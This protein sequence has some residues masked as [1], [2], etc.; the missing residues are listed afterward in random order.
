MDRTS[1]RHFI[2][3]KWV[4]PS[5][6]AYFQSYNP[7]TEEP[8]ADV[9]LGTAR[10]VQLAV[11][12]ARR[13]FD[14]GP[15]PRMAPAARRKILQDVAQIVSD[16]AN[17]L[18]HLETI[19][20]GKPIASTKNR[21][22]PFVC[23]MLRYYA[24]WADKIFGTLLPEN[25]G[26]MGYTIR[27]PVG[28]VGIVTPWNSPLILSVMKIA[29]ALATGNVLIHKPA[30]WTPLSAIRFAE[31]AVEAGL[32]VGVLNVVMGSGS[33]VGRSLVTHSGVDKIS[34]TGETET[35]KEIMRDASTTLKRVSLELGGKSP[36]IIFADAPNL[37][38]AASFAA[39][40]FCANQGQICWAGSRLFVEESIHDVFL[41]KLLAAVERDWRVGDPLDQHTSMGPLISQSQLEQVE[42]YIADGKRGGAHPL[43]EGRRS[44][45][46]G[47]FLTPTIF[48]GVNNRMRIAQEEIFGPVLAVISFKDLPDV[49]KQAN[50]SLYGL[51]AGIWTSDITKAHRLARIIRAG[52]IWINTYGTGNVTV[53]FG[54]YKQSGMGREMGQEALQLFT[55]VKSVWI[56]LPRLNSN[57]V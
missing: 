20:T 8:I 30:S 16:N 26:G 29:P 4:E 18:A 3:G 28:V 46:R 21:D 31:L 57:P 53:P 43:L 5:G 11:E 10:D 51:V 17:E 7:A 13:A 47:H 40:G 55:E 27:E 12:A 52:N 23:E 45:S 19:D 14:D 32:P 49:A 41:E 6:G 54:G 44:R 50:D 34:F 39:R 22:V 42:S 35:G 25:Q 2:E 37:D 38:E 15:W 36:H 33:V 24:G 9:A 48:Q 1:R 56:N